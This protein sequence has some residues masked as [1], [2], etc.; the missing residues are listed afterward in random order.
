MKISK[1][2]PCLGKLCIG[3][4]ILLT[5]VATAPAVEAAGVG[6]AAKQAFDW[7]LDAVSKA[8]A[9]SASQKGAIRRQFEAIMRTDMWTQLSD[10]QKDTILELINDPPTTSFGIRFKAEGDEPSLDDV[11]WVADRHAWQEWWSSERL[12]A[13]EI[14]RL[15][16]R[17]KICLNRSAREILTSKQL[18]ILRLRAIEGMTQAETGEVLGLLRQAIAKR[19]KSVEAKAVQERLHRAYLACV[20]HQRFRARFGY[21]NPA[22]R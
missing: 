18:E 17:S 22:Q 9:V 12:G 5:L 1:N 20:A 21:Q 8:K 15:D 3:I 2:R 16:R 7:V 19:E 6:R 13:G 4:H 14:S 11:P 10:K